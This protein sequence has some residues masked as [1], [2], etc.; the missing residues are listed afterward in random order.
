MA[1]KVTI[2]LEVK[3]N[4]QS[5]KAQLRE[6]QKEVQNL[7]AKYG[8]TSQQVAD[9]AKKV[10]ELKDTIEDANDAIKSFKG[11]GTMLATSKALSSVASG[12]A[13][14][15]GAMGL[16]GAEGKDV[17]KA[18]LKVQSAM[19]IADGLAGL[20]DFG[21][22]F[23]QLKTVAVNAFQ[24]IK[25]AIGSTG[26][27]LLV[28]AVG[29]LY[30]YWD[31]IKAAVSGVS[32]EQSKLNVLSQEN[33]DKEQKKLDAI[34]SQD[35]ILKLQGKSEK[36]ILAIKVKQIDATIKA[37]EVNLQNQIETNKQALEG[38]KR[39]YRLLKSY[40]DF[41]SMPLNFLYSNAAKGINGLISLINKIP[42]VKIDAKLDEKLVEK[43]AEWVTRQIFDPKEL[44]KEGDAM[45]QEQQ[46]ALTKLKNDRAGY[47]LEINNINKQTNKSNAKTQEELNAK[48][49]EENYKN[50]V[51][52]QEEEDLFWQQSKELGD[53][54]IAYK[55]AK[56]QKERE[57]EEMLSAFKIS[58]WEN[59]NRIKEEDAKKEEER[60]A[61]LKALRIQSAYD[62]LSAVSALVQA[63]AGKSEKQQKRAF[64]IQKAISIAQ[65]VIDTYRA[66]NAALASGSAINPAFGIIS[67]ATAIAT[68][69]ANVAVIAKQKWQSPSALSGGSSGRET[70]PNL[71]QGSQ[72]PNLNVIQYGQQSQLAQLQQQPIQAYVVSGEITS[73][74]ALDRNRLR[75]ATL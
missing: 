39:N 52:K 71:S 48:L 31:D 42:G 69:L 23:K 18:L 58:L 40:L 70:S 56:A 47:L 4:S 8:A 22:S 12:F 36:E 45:I 13:A 15:Q 1:E 53:K 46:A 2:D 37:G 65:A 63:F 29:T 43:G 60:Q 41:V 33:L 62:G 67:A 34:G 11:E 19:A 3:D 35:N 17:E 49:A 72:S 28:V 6:A 21:R 9:A 68:G 64:E 20:E 24:S 74:Q 61:Q 26:I 25:T 14:V 32:E 57:D 75:N 27:G 73:Q 66:A 38:E 7:A 16:L 55:E 44:K 5:L 10:A 30:A 51:R 50:A 59:E 54:E